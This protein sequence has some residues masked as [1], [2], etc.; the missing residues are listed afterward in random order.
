MLFALRNLC[1]I[2]AEAQYS[3][4]VRLAQHQPCVQ[5][6]QQCGVQQECGVLICPQ[7]GVLYLSQ[8]VV[9]AW[10]PGM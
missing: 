6:M 5:G 1:P 2:R 4:V 10:G 8:T 3:T 7:H 9:T